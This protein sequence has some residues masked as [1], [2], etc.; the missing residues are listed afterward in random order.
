MSLSVDDFF[1]KFSDF[2]LE[3]WLPT[4]AS[5]GYI[6]PGYRVILSRLKRLIMMKKYNGL[7]SILPDHAMIILTKVD[8]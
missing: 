1:E 8:R 3:T 2:R 7:T 6:L 5:A 4:F